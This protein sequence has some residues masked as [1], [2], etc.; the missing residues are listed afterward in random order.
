MLNPL[1]FM[2]IISF[3]FS[4][5]VR[6][7]ENYSIY[8]L[9]GI[10]FWNMSSLSITAGTGAIVANGNLIQ[11]IK[12]PLWVFP[13]V[14]LGSSMTNLAL[15]LIPYFVVCMFMQVALT[16]QLALL[17]IVLLLTAVF[18]TGI[19]LGLSSLNVFFRD[20]SHVLEPVMTLMFYAT[21]IIY[22]RH[23]PGMPQE[24]VKLLSLN[25]FVHYVE[26]FR[27]TILPQSHSVTIADLGLLAGLSASSL[28]IGGFIYKRSKVK[29]PLAV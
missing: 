6:G 17:P 28:I 22:D 14:P 13:L 4:H 3:V 20:V 7:I 19:S 25:P 27:G 23:A 1:L 12:I 21:P 9:A 5:L 10:L 26:A 24:A 2:V 16:W 29:I 8:V 15:A 18:L 11:K